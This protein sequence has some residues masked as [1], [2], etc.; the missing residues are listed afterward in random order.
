[1]FLLYLNLNVTIPALN[2]NNPIIFRK[3]WI[4]IG[5][6]SYKCVFYGE[7]SFILDSII[8]TTETNPSTEAKIKYILTNRVIYFL[9]V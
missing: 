8:N 9:I 3:C 6:E 7:L 4:I 1:M 2:I 5:T